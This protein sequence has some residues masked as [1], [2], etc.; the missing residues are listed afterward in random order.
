MDETDNRLYSGRELLGKLTNKIKNDNFPFMKWVAAFVVSGKNKE[1]CKRRASEVI[2]IMKHSHIYCVRPIADQLQLF[3]KFL[4]GAPLQ[5]E[6]IG[7][8][9]PHMKVLQRIFSVYRTG[10][11]RMSAFI[12]EE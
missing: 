8:S 11:V 10:S 5:F 4:H 2:R 1:Q 3:Y 9:K 12:L 7:F 6:K